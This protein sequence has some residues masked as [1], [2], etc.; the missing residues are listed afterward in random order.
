LLINLSQAGQLAISERSLLHRRSLPT[1]R[2]RPSAADLPEETIATLTGEAVRAWRTDRFPLAASEPTP[3]EITAFLSR[4]EVIEK[5]T[6]MVRA[7]LGRAEARGMRWWPDETGCRGTDRQDR[8]TLILASAAAVQDRRAPHPTCPVLQAPTGRELLD[9]A[10][11]WEDPRAHRATR[12]ARAP[13][14]RAVHDAGEMRS[15]IDPGGGVSEVGAQEWH[16][17]AHAGPERRNP[18]KP[19]CHLIRTGR[20]GRLESVR[21]V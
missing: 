7:L 21:R 16:A 12:V 17:S 4:P 10:P 3:D 8:H 9:A 6:K 15:R 11:V 18:E 2:G 19:P 1:C 14:E 5:L 13:M 20:N